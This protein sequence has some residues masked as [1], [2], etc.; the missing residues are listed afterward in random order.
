[1]FRDFKGGEDNLAATN[2]AGDQLIAL[3][4]LIA[5]AYT[6]ATINDQKIKRWGIE[7]YVGQVK[8]ADRTEPRHSHVYIGLYGQTWVQF[9]AP[10]AD[11]VAELLQ[12]SP[13]KQHYYR[14]GMRAMSLIQSVL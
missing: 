11:I 8:E 9:M 3:I 2:V 7:K 10:Y 13:H 1:M 14:Q 12:L 5:I 6:A 4:L